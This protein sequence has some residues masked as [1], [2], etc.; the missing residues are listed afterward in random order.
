[1]DQASLAKAVGT[2]RKW[3]IEVEKGKSTAQIGLILRTLRAL[4]IS[5]SDSQQATGS[6]ATPQAADAIDIDR[7]ID[8]LKHPKK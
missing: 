8:S 4:R 6:A 2:S 7:I 3:L 5:L 1:M